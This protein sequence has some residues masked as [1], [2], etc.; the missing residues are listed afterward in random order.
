MFVGLEASETTSTT[1]VEE[2]SEQFTIHQYIT[3][4]LKTAQ[5]FALNFKSTQG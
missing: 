5:K 1:K 3:Y 4:H 2:I